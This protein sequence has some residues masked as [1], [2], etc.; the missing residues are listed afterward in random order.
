LDT[1][2]MRDGILHKA[3]NKVGGT[4]AGKYGEIHLCW[5]VGGG[6]RM[7]NTCTPVADSC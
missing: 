3:D 4:E 5:E 6:F 1:I 7:G 2:R